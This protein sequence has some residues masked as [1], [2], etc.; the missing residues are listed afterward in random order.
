MPGPEGSFDKLVVLGGPQVLEIVEPV[1]VELGLDMAVRE[2]VRGAISEVGVAA[3]GVAGVLIDAASHRRS[4]D[5]DRLNS[6][7][8]G[9][10]RIQDTPIPTALVVRQGAIG[11]FRRKYG[12]GVYTE[13]WAA[14]LWPPEAD[15]VRLWLTN[16]VRSRRGQ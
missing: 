4:D 7:I 15:V 11:H 9:L 12:F 3:E 13:P 8:D 14:M 16:A 6:L 10:W 2:T 5:D 1:A